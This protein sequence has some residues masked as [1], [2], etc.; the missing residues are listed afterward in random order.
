MCE[1]RSTVLSTEKAPTSVIVDYYFDDEVE[2]IH[3]QNQLP[4]WPPVILTSGYPHLNRADLLDKRD[5]AEVTV[6]SKVR[7]Q[8]AS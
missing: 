6:I 3:V 5:T 7:L 4:K 8:K 1:A 2:V